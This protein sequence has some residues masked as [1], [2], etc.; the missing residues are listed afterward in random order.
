MTFVGIAARPGR[1][2]L[3]LSASQLAAKVISAG[4]EHAR[5]GLVAT[6]ALLLGGDHVLVEVDVGAG[7]TL[8]LVEMAGVVAYHGRG[9]SSSW[10]VRATVGE[11]ARLLW[12][13]EPFV[14]SD[15]AD[16]RRSTSVELGSGAVAVLR[17]TLVLGRSGE[18][19]GRL[20][21]T[22][23]VRLGGVPLLSEELAVT[24]ERPTVGVLGTTRGSPHRV[25]DSALAL[26]CRALDPPKADVPG[27]RFDLDGPGT[28]LRWTGTDLAP[29]PIPV[30]WQRERN[31]WA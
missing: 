5:I 31:R 18:Q 27:T 7:C 1:A 11:R 25:V 17:E 3:R 9:A 12:H 30:A 16:V 29:S 21:S 8:E 24:G 6:T 26:G 28:V 22:M 19:G 4:P 23:S 20:V 10:T 15:G 2:A 14:V 13:G